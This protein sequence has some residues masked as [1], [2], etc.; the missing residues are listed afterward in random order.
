MPAWL[1]I[2]GVVT[3]SLIAIFSF[4]GNIE[5]ARTGRLRLFF[6]HIP[7]W[8]ER[9]QNPSFFRAGLALGIY[10]T[11]FFALV[12]LICVAYL[13]EDFGILD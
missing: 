10:R 6:W 13:L 11:G 12:A 4:L 1:A 5:A 8:G 7:G 9:D 3:A 2:I